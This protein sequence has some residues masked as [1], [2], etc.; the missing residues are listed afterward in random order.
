MSLRIWGG[1]PAR[2]DGI[3]D[4]TGVV[5]GQRRLGDN[6]DAAR[7]GEGQRGDIGGRI[8]DGGALRGFAAGALDLL[9]VLMADQHHVKA[10]AGGLLRLQVDLGHEGAGGVDDAEPLGVRLRPHLGG[11]AVGAEDEPGA[12]RHLRDAIDED[13]AALLELP[14]DVAVMNDLVK[15]V[16]G[17]FL[18]AEDFI[19]DIVGADDAGAEAA[20]G[21]EGRGVERS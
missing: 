18:P 21:G 4:V 14:H 10:I 15:G 12:L 5:H 11:D 17:R 16:D 20:G 1:G 6:E 2:A 7:I 9:V 13:G 3:D 19:E 8:D